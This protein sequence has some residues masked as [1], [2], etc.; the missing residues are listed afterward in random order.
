MRVC[1]CAAQLRHTLYVK[2]S[3]RVAYNL[4]LYLTLLLKFYLF[5]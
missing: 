5:T 1:V 3:V 4:P 2:Y